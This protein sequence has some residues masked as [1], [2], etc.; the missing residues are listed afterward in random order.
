MNPFPN[1]KIF[2]SVRFKI[3]TDDKPNDAQMMIS[4]TLSQMTNSRLFQTERICLQMTISNLMKMAE[5]SLNG[6]KT[7]WEKE[8]LLVSSNFSFSH[9]VFKRLVLQTGKNQGLFAK[10]LQGRKCCEKRRKCWLPTMF[11]VAFFTRATKPPN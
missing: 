7:L 6:L 9:C 11:S 4:V 10:G 5:I 3:S 2:H 8:K 1:N